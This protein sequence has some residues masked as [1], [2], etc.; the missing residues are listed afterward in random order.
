MITLQNKHYSHLAGR[1]TEAQ[2]GGG[3]EKGGGF[4]RLLPS[5]LPNSL[6]CEAVFRAER[7]AGPASP[8]GLIPAAGKV[9]D[10]G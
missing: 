7:S 3:S 1:H 2:L 10:L 5:H 6:D 8:A 4:L 9:S